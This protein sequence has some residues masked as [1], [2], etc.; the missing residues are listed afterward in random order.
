LHFGKPVAVEKPPPLLKSWLAS[1]TSM[2]PAQD[3]CSFKPEDMDGTPVVKA[4]IFPLCTVGKCLLIAVELGI[5]APRLYG[6]EM[7]LKWD[8]P[9]SQTKSASNRMGKAE[10]LGS[11]HI[12]RSLWL[13][14]ATYGSRFTIF[15][16][17]AL[18]SYRSTAS[19]SS[20]PLPPPEKVA[21]KKIQEPPPTR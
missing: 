10:T 11:C 5:E 2:E 12:A 1:L 9:C 17:P 18:A 8:S 4:L 21:A 13:V 20:V 16:A 6:V 3:S 19:R 15:S 7:R 14:A